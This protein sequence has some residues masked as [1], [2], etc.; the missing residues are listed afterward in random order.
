M[1]NKQPFHVRVTRVG[2]ENGDYSFYSY[3]DI[4]APDH[5]EA[6]ST[7]RKQFCEEFGAPYDKTTAYTFNKQQ[8]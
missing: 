5:N 8:S 2:D 3:Y 6:E 1:S 7:A 4:K